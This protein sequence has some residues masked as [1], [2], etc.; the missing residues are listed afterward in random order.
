MVSLAAENEDITNDKEK[1]DELCLVTQRVIKLQSEAG[2]LYFSQE[3]T[4]NSFPH[5]SRRLDLT[6]LFPYFQSKD[7]VFDKMNNISE[8][9]RHFMESYAHNHSLSHKEIDV[10]YTS[11]FL[12]VHLLLFTFLPSI[13][14][15]SFWGVVVDWLG[16]SFVSIFYSHKL[17]KLIVRVCPTGAAIDKIS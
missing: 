7:V 8:E 9:L 14:I 2:K 3:V 5:V 11:L 1:A 4:M 16:Y 15:C 13:Y 17:C 12:S 6:P 10:T